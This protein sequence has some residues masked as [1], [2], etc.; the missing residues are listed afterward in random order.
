MLGGGWPTLFAQC[1]ISGLYPRDHPR[2]VPLGSFPYPIWKQED[3]PTGGRDRFCFHFSVM[4]VLLPIGQVT[5]LV[6]SGPRRRALGGLE[7]PNG[8]GQLLT[9]W[10]G[11]LGCCVSVAVG[12][13]GELITA[14]VKARLAEAFPGQRQSGLPRRPKLQAEAGSLTA[15]EVS[16]QEA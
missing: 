7:E 6:L 14:N 10:G 11:H 5:V 2:L 4:L 8:S 3:P 9:R 1:C 12:P 15:E 16:S 13:V